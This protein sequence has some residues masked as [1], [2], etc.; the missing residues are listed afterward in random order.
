[1]PSLMELHFYKAAISDAG[2]A[3]LADHPSL[4]ALGIYY[5]AVGDDVLAPLG[6][7]PLLSFVK[8]YGTKVSPAAVEAF[9]EA[10]GVTVDQRSAV[11]GVGCQPNMEPCQISSIHANRPAQKAGLLQGDFILRFGGKSVKNFD[12]LTELIRKCDVDEDVEVEVLRS[13]AD[14]QN[15]PRR[16]SVKLKLAAWDLDAAVINGRR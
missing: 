14:D 10:S 2:L 8:L 4:R 13:I 1:M 12:A 15:G 9:K 5:T 16:V 11:L 6:K 7:L 3:P